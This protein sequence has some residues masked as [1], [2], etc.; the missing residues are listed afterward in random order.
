MPRHD[1][2]SQGNI[3]VKARQQQYILDGGGELES[4]IMGAFCR[5]MDNG[6]KNRHCKVFK[7]GLYESLTTGG[8]QEKTTKG[9]Q[10]RCQKVHTRNQYISI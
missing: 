10:R 8:S 6:R 7:T 2:V 3:H 1:M 9:K 4:D 5:L